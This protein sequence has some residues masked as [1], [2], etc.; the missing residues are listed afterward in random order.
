MIVSR[1]HRLGEPVILAL[2]T[3][4]GPEGELVRRAPKAPELGPELALLAATYGWTPDVV[5]SLTVPQLIYY[6]RW[7]PLVEARRAYPS[8]SLEA[9]VLN[10]VGGKPEPV[11]DADAS[12]PPTP[13]HRLF[14]PE[15]RLPYWARLEMPAGAWTG[16]SARE[17]LARTR[18]L[19]PWALALLDFRRLERLAAERTDG[20]TFLLAAGLPLA[21]YV[22]MRPETGELVG[23]LELSEELASAPAPTTISAHEIRMRLW[24]EG[25]EDED[26]EDHAP[27]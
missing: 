8:A 1:A 26:P 24:R 5:E 4:S 11:E 15:E 9:T 20:T 2:G 16:A 19:P 18:D 23:I 12:S 27:E 3:S 22:M 13:A 21:S 6:Q 25:G 14:D 17:A 10:V 7:I